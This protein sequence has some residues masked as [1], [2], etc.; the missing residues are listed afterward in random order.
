[1]KKVRW[2]L[3]IIILIGVTIWF[4]FFH[5]TY[6]NKTVAASAD[7][8][9]AVD[10]KRNTNTV[11]A[12][13]ITHPT[14]WNLRTVFNTTKI[15]TSFNWKNA[16]NIP[17]YIFIFHSK[18]QPEN[19]YYS[20]LTIKHEEDF[21]K[22]LVTYH[23]KQGLKENDKTEYYSTQLGVALI[24]KDDQILI[25]TLVKDRNL[26]HAVANE[27][28]TKNEYINSTTL[29]KIIAPANHFS[30]FIKKNNFLQDDAVINGNFFTGELN[31]DATFL[32]NKEFY[33]TENTF[34]VCS[35]S[36][37]NIAFTQP[38]TSVYKLIPDSIKSNISTAINF[39]IDSILIAPNKN[40]NID[41]AG[42]KTRIDSAITYDYDDNF[43]KR[44][45]VVKNEIQEPDF[46]CSIVTNNPNQLF[47]YWKN[48]KNIQQDSVGNLFVSVPFVKSYVY[49]NLQ[50]T[51]LI[52]S[53]NYDNN[54]IEKFNCIAC[55]YFNTNKLPANAFKYLPDYLSNLLINIASINSVV[56]K[57]N[58]RILFKLTVSTTNKS[59]PF[60][61]SF[62]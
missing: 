36:L 56:T 39:N 5:K 37:L 19:I 18:N 52:T 48:N 1:M 12:Y 54:A 32:P 13:F 6:S 34:N 8:V 10:V 4:C 44:E 21:E 3:I 11:I 17:D 43:N 22:G 20:V 15:D 59:K 28:F 49:N 40:Y 9:L 31:I 60:L 50:D 24:K 41:I 25:T 33:F 26:L 27:I 23:F 38:A 14:E 35:K 46:N 2:L 7:M 51:L 53:N 55:L 45:H 16:I 29:A 61:L 47:Q 62:W 58:D 57:D 42:F 30:I